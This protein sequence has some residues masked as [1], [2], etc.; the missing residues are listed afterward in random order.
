M[1]TGN[2]LFLLM[3]VG[4]FASF[5][6]VLAY[7]SWQQARSRATVVA[8]LAKHPAPNDALQV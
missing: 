1:T 5:S 8:K 2:V 4:M 7:Q 6:A 3:V